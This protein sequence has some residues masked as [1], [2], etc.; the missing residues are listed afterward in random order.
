M[1]PFARLT[2][3]YA[4]AIFIATVSINISLSKQLILFAISALRGSTHWLGYGS[5]CD[6]RF[7]AASFRAR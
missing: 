3:N 4:Y 6:S 1:G 7:E 5:S 2:S